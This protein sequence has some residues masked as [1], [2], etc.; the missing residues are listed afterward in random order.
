M[1]SLAKY[2]SL[3]LALILCLGVALAFT[4]CQNGSGDTET[5]AE[6]TG[7]QSGDNPSE[8]GKT[9]YTIKVKSAGG[10]ALSGLNVYVYTDDTLSD[11]VNF[12]ATNAEGVAS[13]TL[14]TSQKYVAVLSGLPEG[15]NPAAY[16]PL[17]GGT[18]EITVTSSVIQNTDQTGK[19]YKLGDII[20]DFKVVDT[21]GKT[22]QLSEILKE[23]K[24]VL[25]NFWYSK[26]G[27][28]INEFPYMNASYNKYK[29]KVEIVA[30]NHYATD[31]EEGIKNFRDSYYE[32]P[33]DFI[34]AKDFTGLQS[35]FSIEGYPTSIVIDRY[36]MICLVE[37]GGLPS[38]APFN[39]I[40]KYF[41]ADDYVQKTFASLNELT[42]PEKPTATMPSSE[43][44]AAVLN[45]GNIQVT[46][47]PETGEAA[48]QTWPFIIGEKDGTPCIYNSN[49]DKDSTW[50]IMYAN[51]TLK[52]GEAV[53][54]DYLSSCEA[55]ND[56]LVTLVDRKDIYRI[57]GNE[58][59]TWETCYTFVAIEDG[60]YELAFS[61]IK[62]GSDRKGDD[63]VYIKN[64][65]VIKESDIDQPT[66]I[67][68]Y[69]ATHQKADGFGYESYITPVYN[70]E[71][72]FYHVGTKDGPL[73]LADLLNGTRFSNGSVYTMAAEGKIVLD[74]KNYLDDITKYASYASNATIMGL[75]SVNQ[76]LAELLKIV[77]DAV[78]LE[79][80]PNEWLQMCC[81]YDGYGGGYFSDPIEG[82][83]PHTAYEVKEGTTA[84]VTY[85]R[86]IMPRGLLNKFVPTRSGAYRITSK[87]T[88]LV[89][90]WIFDADLEEYYV[91]EGGERLNEDTTN[92][93]MVVYLEAGKIYY[94]DI[95]YYD[96]YAVG[97]ITFDILYLGESYDH[98]TVAAPGY[99]TFPDGSV[100]DGPVGDLEEIIALGI[101][102][103]LG[104]DGY[105]H[106]KRADGSLGSIIYVDFTGITNIF[107]RPIKDFTAADGTVL[108]GLIS[109]GAFDFTLSESDHIIRTYMEKH[110][111]NTRQYLQDFWGEE[112]EQQAANHLLDEVL[113]GK[114]HGKGKDRTAEISAYLDKVIAASDEA[115]ELEGCV[116]V[117]EK[118]A[119]LLQELM[120]KYTF[121]GVDHSWTKISY[122]YQH[123]GA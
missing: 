60:T 91:Y 20:R 94:I 110:G 22:Q 73:L 36:G 69:A 54:F 64:L 31:S 49:A 37:V 44:I 11:I 41:S 32:E 59:G 61:Y 106:E 63:R 87:S 12:A 48:E 55:G 25:I 57:S 82:I 113:A 111:E 70:E 4:G 95:C 10:M 96:V 33:L 101:D 116:A 38:E 115:P 6:T 121:A 56:F 43:E 71:D 67:P 18:T 46:Y 99:F 40:F 26:C 104:D 39:A 120:D 51:I 68:R 65:R 100:A 52:K 108:K 103:A 13:L 62:D 45:S 5:T 28:C 23:K 105:Y 112:F 29:D 8:P 2:L 117:D 42:P 21:E 97:T 109:M 118:L 77:A 72:G 16:Y 58:V 86:V 81:Y 122:Y 79:D 78:G 74:G 84:S 89:E 14:P 9:T 114:T 80:D 107:D 83:A 19:F 75:C 119:E 85:D 53:A 92:V 7:S 17:L 47:T 34:M 123:L 1:K 35:A 3:A 102:V 90:G 76:E 24:M 50:A 27:P 93:S 30:L 98:F 66:F 88:Q 15:Y